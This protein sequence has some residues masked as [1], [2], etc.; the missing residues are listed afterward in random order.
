MSRRGSDGISKAW[1]PSRPGSVTGQRHPVK[2]LRFAPTRF[3]GGCLAAYPYL[4]AQNALESFLS[5]PVHANFFACGLDKGAIIMYISKDIDI[6][7]NEWKDSNNRK[8]LLL[9]GVRQCGKTS[10]VRHL[11][12]QFGSYV[13]LNFDKKPSLYR[14]CFI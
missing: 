12:E 3:A 14:I 6:A 5:H 9:R 10:A 2:V 1:V 4:L 7:L 8:P 11:A 13:E